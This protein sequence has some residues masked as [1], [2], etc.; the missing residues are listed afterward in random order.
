M[1][2]EGSQIILA[3]DLLNLIIRLYLM[4]PENS[5]TLR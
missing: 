4:L 2:L 5:H 3:E 1:M